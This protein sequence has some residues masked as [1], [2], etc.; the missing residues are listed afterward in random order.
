MLLGI[1]YGE[2]KIGIALGAM[3]L[4]DPLAVIQ[5][6]SNEYLLKKLKEIIDENK[7]EKIIIGL[8]EGEMANK[9]KEFGKLLEKE[10]NLPIIYEDETLSS[11]DAID[12]SIGAGMRRKKRKEMEDAFAAAIMLQNFLDKQQ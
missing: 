3:T 9:T 8:S 11:E 5:Y 2:K 12:M 10:F 7:I 4:A 6:Q 1:D